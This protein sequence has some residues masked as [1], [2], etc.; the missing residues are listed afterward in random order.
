MH[1]V[2]EHSFSAARCRRTRIPARGWIYLGG[3]FKR[4][5]RCYLV[6]IQLAGYILVLHAVADRATVRTRSRV[7]ASEPLLYQ[8]LHLFVGELVPKLYRR[9]A[10]YGGQDCVHQESYQLVGTCR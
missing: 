1:G 8:R 4:A 7:A 5:Q 2:R 9:V 10:R 6:P 3:R